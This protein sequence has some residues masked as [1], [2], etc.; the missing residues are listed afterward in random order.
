MATSFT[1]PAN[2]NAPS[3]VKEGAEFSD[4]ATF[5]IDGDQIHI[6]NIGENKTPIGGDKEKGNK[7]K[8]AKQAIKEQLSSMEDKKGG[9]EMEDSGEDYAEGGKEE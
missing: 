7:P 9:A 3:G 2:Y 1:I 8:G 6:L 4:I 5:K